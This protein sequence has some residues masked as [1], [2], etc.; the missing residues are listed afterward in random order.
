MRLG[1]RQLCG[2]AS[3]PDN[4]VITAS[5]GWAK[6]G[7]RLREAQGQRLS[8]GGAARLRHDPVWCRTSA[9]TDLELTGVLQDWQN[10]EPKTERLMGQQFKSVVPGWEM[11]GLC[12]FALCQ[13]EQSVTSRARA[14]S[15]SGASPRAPWHQRTTQSASTTI[16]FARQLHLWLFE[17]CAV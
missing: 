16:H 5:Y 8:S 10:S 11:N 3:H 9:R 12:N 17:V 1:A 15:R 2:L 6:E 13:T 7:C 4:T 14:E